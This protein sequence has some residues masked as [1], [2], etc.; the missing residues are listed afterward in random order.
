MEKH[1]IFSYTLVVLMPFSA[2]CS[3]DVEDEATPAADPT[4]TG[5]P[6]S[7][8]RSISTSAATGDDIPFCGTPPQPNPP[9]WF[10]NAINLPIGIP[11][12]NAAGVRSVVNVTQPGLTLRRLG[13]SVDITHTFRGDLIIQLIA[14]TGQVATLSNRQGGSA[15]NFVAKS[16]DLSQSFT[17][18]TS[19]SGSWI[20][21]VRDV[22]AI[23]VGQLNSFCL[24]IGSN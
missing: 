7:S 12:N 1:R 15:D 8:D 5:A 19:A 24:T 18:G 9:W 23:D 16:L 21:S 20:L 2:A 4:A 10:F 6:P 14:P 22:A 3:I 11:D 13:V 17:Q